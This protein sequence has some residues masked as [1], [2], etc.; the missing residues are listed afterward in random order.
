MYN[1]IYSYGAN[2]P[3]YLGKI[4]EVVNETIPVLQ[5][6]SHEVIWWKSFLERFPRMGII[7]T[8]KPPLLF[9]T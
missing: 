6:G 1:S 8:H 5:P 7:I 4:Y 3:D 2:F 9:Q